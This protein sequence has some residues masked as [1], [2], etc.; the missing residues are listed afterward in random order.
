MAPAVDAALARREALPAPPPLPADYSFPAIP[1]RWA[2]ETGSAEMHD[3]LE[4]FADVQA[5]GMQDEDLGLL[6]R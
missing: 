5:R 4:H 1:R 2:D 6:G 3:W